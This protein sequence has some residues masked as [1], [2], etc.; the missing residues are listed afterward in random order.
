MGCFSGN[1]LSDVAPHLVDVAMGRKYAELVIQK[2]RLVNVH[3]AEILPNIDVA[4]AAGRIALVG[5]ACHTIG[6]ETTVIDAGNM[7]LVP[8]F[9]DGHIHVESSMVTVSGFAQAVL[10]HGTTAI[11]M[12]PHEIAN[13]FGLEGIRLMH[14]EGKN[15]PLRVFTTVPSCVPAAPGLED[16]GAVIGP[17]E[18]REA[19]SWEGV[20]GLGE[21]MNF[22]GVLANDH[23]VHAIIKETLDVGKVVTGHY[24]LPTDG[25]G[26]QAYIAAGVTSCHESV[27]KDDVLEKVRSGMFVMLR[28]GS[29]WHDV[30]E[31]I[32]AITE[33]NIDT[34]FCL[35]CSDDTHPDTLLQQGHLNHVILRAIQEGVNPVRAI[36]M[37]TI[38][39]ARYFKVDH[40]LG[41]IAPG[42]YAD[43]LLLSDLAR[44]KVEQVFIAGVP[45][46]KEGKLLLN[47]PASSYPESVR[48]SVRLPKP[49]V[50]ADFQ[51]KAPACKENVTL[52]VIQIEEAQVGTKELLLSV[53]AANGTV[54]ADPAKD[55]AKVAVFERHSGCGEGALGFVTGFGLTAGAVASTVAH[56]SHNLLIVGTNDDDMA[57]AGNIL[58]EHGGGMVA[59]LAGE[60][61]ALVALPVAGL[62]SNRPVKEVAAAVSSLA[63]AWRTLG[64]KLV[65][66][67]MTMALLSLPVIPELRLTNRGLINVAAFSFVSL[68][69]E[70]SL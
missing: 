25:P 49:L 41:S 8:G 34:S 15:L 27:H 47:L 30:K 5:D 44:V 10:P 63:K 12:D 16:T 14:E 9:L 20:V 61:L 24:A 69:P 26:L 64:C 37:A 42:K 58:A 50:A 22:P 65:S 32:R 52:R 11:F 28:E 70:D 46:A 3:S 19:M 13:V 57:M 55:L 43:M 35:L 23:A 6:P 4:V 56:D 54:A 1:K 59:V 33:H 36:Q 17:T 62:M 31:T 68:F 21:M 45:V 38:N 48:N 39:T 7:I 60:V 29:A 66:P 40:E 67:F 51:V 2:A 18:V 53:P